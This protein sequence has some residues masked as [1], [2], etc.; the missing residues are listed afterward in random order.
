[1]I[2]QDSAVGQSAATG[3]MSAAAMMTAGLKMDCM[4]L[5]ATTLLLRTLVLHTASAGSVEVAVVGFAVV[6]GQQRRGH[7]TGSLRPWKL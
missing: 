4:D 3:G 5:R 1:M 6:Q 7:R 2:A